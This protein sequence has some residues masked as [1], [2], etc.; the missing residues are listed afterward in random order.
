MIKGEQQHRKGQKM[1]REYNT[2]RAE[3]EDEY[4]ERTPEY[5]AT[6]QKYAD[7]ALNRY[8]SLARQGIAEQQRQNYLTDIDRATADSLAQ[9]SSRRG[10]L[11]GIGAMDRNRSDAYRDLLEMDANTRLQNQYNLAAVAPQFEG[12]GDR[13]TMERETFLSDLDLGDIYEDR[14]YGR[15][16]EEEG[17]RKNQEGWAQFDEDL[18]SWMT[19]GASG[20]LGGGGGMMGGGNQQQSSGGQQTQN[21]YSNPNTQRRQRRQPSGS[22]PS[23]GRQ[24]RRYSEP[25]DFQGD[26]DGMDDGYGVRS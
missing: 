23:G 11:M 15:W 2:R 3:W 26:Y 4:N 24:R 16:L 17:F 19:M 9:R 12:A 10:G 25:S 18:M 7:K 21:P 1:Q 22:Q 6:I 20:G 14:D 8:E 5:A 13:F